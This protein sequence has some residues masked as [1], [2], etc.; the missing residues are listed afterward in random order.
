MCNFYEI[1]IDHAA[2][3]AAE[4]VEEIGVTA[5]RDPIKTEGREAA[6]T[7]DLHQDLEN[8]RRIRRIEREEAQAVI[9]G[10]YYSNE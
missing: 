1:I 8:R 2:G 3:A 9:A 5:E 7:V 6:L 4:A 10:I